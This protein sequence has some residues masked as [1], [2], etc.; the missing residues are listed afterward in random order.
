MVGTLR[1]ATVFA[2]VGLA[3]CGGDPCAD[4][5]MLDSEQGLIVTVD[6]HPTGWGLESCFE[7]HH[8]ATLHRIGCTEGVDMVALRELVEAEG[9]ESCAACHGDNGVT[10][11]VDT[12]ADTG[13]EEEE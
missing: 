6:E 1:L 2:L 9:L 12:G 8:K 3:A 7:C 11:Q 10:E 4:G 5:S 13:A